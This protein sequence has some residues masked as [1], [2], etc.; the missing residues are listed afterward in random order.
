MIK[1]YFFSLYSSGLWNEPESHC[2]G[3]IRDG[4]FDGQIHT[5]S[6][7]IY[8]IGKLP[9]QSPDSHQTAARQPPDSRQTAARQPPDSHKTANRQ[10]QYIFLSH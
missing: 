1:I 9:R 3:A 7:G 8:Y 2:F 10:S 4:V 6:D 5:A